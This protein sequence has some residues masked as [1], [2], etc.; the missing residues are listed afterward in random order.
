MAIG[1]GLFLTSFA[2]GPNVQVLERDGFSKVFLLVRLVT[3]SNEFVTSLLGNGFG[4]IGRARH[5]ESGN[6]DKSLCTKMLTIGEEVKIFKIHGLTLKVILSKELINYPEVRVTWYYTCG[7][8][9]D[10]RTSSPKCPS[11]KENVVMVIGFA[12]R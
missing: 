11:R 9:L 2:S 4:F 12:E 6:Y 8:L 5:D 1:R 3:P 10:G 7:I